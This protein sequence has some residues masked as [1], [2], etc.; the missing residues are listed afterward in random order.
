MTTAAWTGNLRFSVPTL[1]AGAAG[2]AGFTVNAKNASGTVLDPVT[3]GP[4]DP[5]E[6]RPQAQ[7]HLLLAGAATY[8]FVRIENP[9]APG[10]PAPIDTLRVVVP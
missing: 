5:G 2:L 3:V 7:F 9:N 1:A 4:V 8:E 6:S 10:A